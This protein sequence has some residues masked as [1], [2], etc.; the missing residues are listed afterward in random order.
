[1]LTY[2]ADLYGHQFLAVSPH[3]TTQICFDCG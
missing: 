1:M 3:H 2:K